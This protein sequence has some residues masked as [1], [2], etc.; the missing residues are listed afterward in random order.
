MDGAASRAET[1]AKDKSI[2]SLERTD[3]NYAV[4]QPMPAAH[5][6]STH[7]S[8]NGVQPGSRHPAPGIALS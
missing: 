4:R 8:P 3:L 6:V 7:A 5:N 1:R 2:Y